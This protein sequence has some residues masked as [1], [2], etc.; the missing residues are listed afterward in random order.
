MQKKLKKYLIITGGLFLIFILFTVMVKTVDVKPVGPDR[1]KVGLASVNQCVFKFFGVNLLWYDITDWLGV[2]AIV[3][4]LGFAVLGLFQLIKRK[5]IQKVDCRILLLGVFYVMVIAVYL[6]FEVV[7]VNDRPIILSESLEASFPS[8][9]V[10]FVNCIMATA[11][12]QFHYYLR[13]RKAWLWMSDIVSVLIITATVIGRLI[14]GVHWFTDIVAG[15]LLSS[16]LIAL[17]C[18]ALLYFESKNRVE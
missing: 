3:F 11:M 16:V 9:H 14:S 10:M 12:L 18:S 1:S 7:V 4:A 15:I 5:S 13:E 8:S 6:F 17:Y 2:F